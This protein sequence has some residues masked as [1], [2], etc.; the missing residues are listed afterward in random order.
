VA[1]II[2][3]MAVRQMLFGRFAFRIESGRLE[4]TLW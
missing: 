2:Y 3:E 1:Q 4:G